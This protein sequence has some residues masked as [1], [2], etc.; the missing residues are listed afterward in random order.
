MVSARWAKSRKLR[1]HIAVYVRVYMRVHERGDWADSYLPGCVVK[2]TW[3]FSVVT[4]VPCSQHDNRVSRR[5]INHDRADP[6]WRWTRSS[7]WDL[8]WDFAAVRPVSPPP[9][10]PLRSEKEERSHGVIRS[11]PIVPAIASFCDLVSI[12]GERFSAVASR[13]PSR[14]WSSVDSQSR[15]RSDSFANS[16]TRSSIAPSSVRE[17]KNARRSAGPRGQR[18]MI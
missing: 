16:D 3:P 9:L 12:N 17:K 10:S 11:V 13:F 4:C 2:T 15:S 1:L 7:W 5:S 6:R 18:G 8:P 14:S